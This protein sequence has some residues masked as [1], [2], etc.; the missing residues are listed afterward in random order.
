MRLSEFTTKNALL[1]EGGNAWHD[2]LATERI[3]RVYVV[4]TIE[5]LERITGLPLLNNV[6]G[7]AGRKET[8]GDIDLGVSP[9]SISKDQLVG[10]LKAWAD[11][12]DPKALVRKTGISVH[13]RCPIIGKANKAYIQVDF[14]FIENLKFAQWSMTSR[15]ESKYKNQYRN[16][17]L[18]SIAK[19]LG[20]SYSMTKGLLNRGTSELIK[21]GANINHMAKLLLG[22][23]AKKTDLETVESILD[24]L[25]DDPKRNEKLE[26]ARETFKKF[27]LNPGV[28]K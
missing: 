14:M 22:P 5:F 18:A 11:I 25:K 3:D 21:N 13:F 26:D 20:L 8:S 6:L 2:D 15:E 17:L 9:K 4:P 23:T 24:A 10:K 19:T 1:I 12:N 27:G 7:S 16:I 28:L